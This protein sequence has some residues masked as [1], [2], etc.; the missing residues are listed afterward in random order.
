MQEMMGGHNASARSG[1]GIAS[2]LMMAYAITI[3]VLFLLAAVLTFTDFPEKYTT[4]A[5]MLATLAG[6]FIAGYNA[7]FRNEKNGLVKGAV[8]GVVYMLIL[9]LLGSIVFKDYHLNQHAIVM[10][11]TGLLAGAIGAVLG[12]KRKSKPA[13]R[14]SGIGKSP[15]LLKKYRK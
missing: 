5:V 9:Y 10:I 6:L 2:I 3:P 7:G 12:A 4:I 15:D 11:L 14:F 13:R 1:F 8:A